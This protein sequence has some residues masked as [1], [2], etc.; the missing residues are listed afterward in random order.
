M[1][2]VE[3][4][5]TGGGEAPALLVAEVGLGRLEVGPVGLNL[6]ALGRDGDEVAGDAL[7][8]GL[9]QQALDDHL[10]LR[11]AALAEVVVAD[12]ALRVGDVDGGPVVVRERLPDRVVAVERDRVV[13]AQVLRGPADVVDV[14]LERELGRVH[15]DDDQPLVARIAR[16]RRGR[17]RASGAS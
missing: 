17:R 16:P 8:S 15:A 1:A 4:R 7:A 6:E 12:P 11:V 14:A 5:A 2:F 10:A 3:R 9:A 13:D